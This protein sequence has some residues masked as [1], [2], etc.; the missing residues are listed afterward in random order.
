MDDRG[1]ATR[2]VLV[3]MMGAGKSTVGREVAARLGW[4]YLDNDD[5]VR[6]IS[7]MDPPALAAARGVAALHRAEIAAAEAV[8]RRPGPHVAGLAGFVVTDLRVRGLLRERAVVAW[9]RARPETLRARI[10]EGAGRRSDATSAA[11]LGAVAAEREPQFAAVADHVLDVDDRDVDS[12]AAEITAWVEAA[13]AKG[14][15]GG[16]R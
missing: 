5:L 14:P 6:E 7:D 13:P 3:G 9:L 11:W 8:L 16:P 15:N 4:P 2:L 10:G 1:D 12:L